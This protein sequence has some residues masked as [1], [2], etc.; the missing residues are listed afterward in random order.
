MKVFMA[1]AVLLLCVLT[2]VAVPHH[3]RLDDSNTLNTLFQTYRRFFTEPSDIT[4]VG[5]RVLYFA[6]GILGVL[7]AFYP[8]VLIPLL[9]WVSASDGNGR[10]T[11]L[12]LGGLAC[13][14]GAVGNMWMMLVL[15][16]NVG[17]YGA[18]QSNKVTL[19]AWCIPLW[20][21]GAALLSVTAGLSSAALSKM[22]RLAGG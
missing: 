20:Q 15:N 8:A 21:L 10:N 5:L 12:V 4:S 22:A 6:V 19:I 1:T 17:T 14:V 2:V 13:A 7:S 3:Q 9:R 11:L 18:G 16:L